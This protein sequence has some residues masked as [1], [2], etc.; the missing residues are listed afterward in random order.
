M[1]IPLRALL[2]AS[3]LT[4]AGPLAAGDAEDAAYQERLAAARAYVEM[5]MQDVEM[6]RI[7]E[8]MWRGALPQFRQI[9]GGPLTEQQMTDLQAL[10]MEVFEAPMR[11]VM[12]DQDKLMADLLSLEEI[13]AL[14]DFYATPEGRS[15]MRKLPDI[16]ARQ[17]PQ[18]MALVQSSLPQILPRVRDILRPE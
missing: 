15:V 18:I 13:A 4:L 3:S 1:L 6:A 9:A 10:Y 17:Q 7:V 8:Q 5:S 14:R 2:L 16:L 12:R 11:D